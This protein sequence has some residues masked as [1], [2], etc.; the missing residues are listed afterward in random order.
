MIDPD[1]LHLLKYWKKSRQQPFDLTLQLQICKKTHNILDSE[2]EDEFKHALI[3]N[4][5]SENI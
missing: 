4:Y 3:K 1:T 5:V 2:V